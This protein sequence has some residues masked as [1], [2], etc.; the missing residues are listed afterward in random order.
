MTKLAKQVLAP[1]AV[2]MLAMGVG[3]AFAYEAGDMVIRG[4]YAS[5]NPDSSSDRVL[6]ASLLAD[7]NTVEVDD[8][9]AAGIS[10]TYMLDNNLGLEVLAATPF[11]HDIEG[12]DALKGLDV[13]ETKHLPPTV[14]FQYNMDVSEQVNIYGGVGINYTTFFDEETTDALNTALAGVLGAAVNSSKLELEDSWGLA[15]S[16]GVDFKIDEQ[17]GINAGLYWVDIDTTASVYVNGAKATEF[18]VEID[19]MVYRLNVVYK[20]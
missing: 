17:W 7:Q 13:G 19:P 8:G 2:S 12:A 5:V 14:S 15:F 4:G 10:L 1:V 6:P 9:A 18:D 11:S 16:A 20:L 3:S